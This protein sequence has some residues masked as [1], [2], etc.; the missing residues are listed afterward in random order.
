MKLDIQI[1]LEELQR[2]ITS[3]LRSCI[4]KAVPTDATDV[5]RAIPYPRILSCDSVCNCDREAP[6]E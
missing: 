4:E 5:K 6:L 1:H 2:R 3:H